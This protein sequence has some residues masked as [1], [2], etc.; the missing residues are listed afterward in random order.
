[1]SNPLCVQGSLAFFNPLEFVR[2]IQESRT[3][4]RQLRRA[5]KWFLQRFRQVVTEAFQETELDFSLPAKRQESETL[6][7]MISWSDRE[8][9]ELHDLIIEKSLEDLKHARG[10]DTRREILEWIS[11]QDKANVP[12]SFESCCAISGLDPDPIRALVKK[13]YIDE[14]KDF[15]AESDAAAAAKAKELLNKVKKAT[16]GVAPAHA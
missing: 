14:I 6:K 5:Q 16:I 13:L 9:I 12:F 10:R 4:K 15:I 7:E 11:A 8:I 3:K 2:A 1:M